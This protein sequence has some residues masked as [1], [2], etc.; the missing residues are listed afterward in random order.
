MSDV[1]DFRYNIMHMTYFLS[2]FARCRNRLT[3]AEVCALL[4]DL[5]AVL[6]S[7]IEIVPGVV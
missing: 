1:V 5:V 7:H 3:L 2:T 4:I 6:L